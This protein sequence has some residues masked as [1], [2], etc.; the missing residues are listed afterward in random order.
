MRRSKFDPIAGHG[1]TEMRQVRPEIARVVAVEMG[2]STAEGGADASRV[3]GLQDKHT[4]RCEQGSHLL[5]QIESFD[6]R[7]MLDHVEAKDRIVLARD[8]LERRVGVQ[9][10]DAGIDGLVQT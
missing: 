10:L 2:H 4:A 7:Q 6:E 3:R 1:V 9:M 8:R 5:K